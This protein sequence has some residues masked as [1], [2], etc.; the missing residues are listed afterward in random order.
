M[1]DQGPEQGHRSA[2]AELRVSAEDAIRTVTVLGEVDISNVGDL[3]EQ[4][5]DLPNDSLGVVLDL[6]EATFIDSAT[7]RML[8]AVRKR[9]TLRRQRLVLVSPP[10]SPVRRVLDLVGYP[11]EEH[12]VQPSVEGARTALQVPGTNLD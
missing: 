8:F 12:T 4:V 5:L 2:L 1:A 6:G 11:L 7:I 3:E 9:L 10:G